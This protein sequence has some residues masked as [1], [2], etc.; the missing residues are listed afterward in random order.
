MLLVLDLL[1]L[2]YLSQYSFKGDFLHWFAFRFL[3]KLTIL[4]DIYGVR[5]ENSLQS[6]GNLVKGPKEAESH[7][8]LYV[9]SM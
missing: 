2:M 5:C 9:G 1:N 4:K 3:A 7:P 6:E 8:F